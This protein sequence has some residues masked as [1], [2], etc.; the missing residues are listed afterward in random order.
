M[1]GYGGGETLTEST[2]EDMNVIMQKL[3]DFDNASQSSF[4]PKERHSQKQEHLNL[5]SHLTLNIPVLQFSLVNKSM[6]QFGSKQ[7]MMVTV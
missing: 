6:R 3:K 5:E 4:A 7:F 1:M 2:E